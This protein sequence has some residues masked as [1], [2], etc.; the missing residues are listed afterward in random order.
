MCVNDLRDPNYDKKKSGKRL[1]EDA[2]KIC[3]VV[4]CNYP[5][6]SKEGPGDK[7][8]CREHQLYMR[9]YGGP[10]RLDRPHTFHRSKEYI[11]IECGWEILKDFR[12]ADIKSEMKKRQVARTLLHGDHKI[13]QADGGDDSAENIKSLCAVCHAKKTMQNEDYLSIINVEKET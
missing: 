13:R 7:S 4:G 10:G 12:L 1:A 2:H 5:L 11:C 9:E 6:T 3:I 8:L